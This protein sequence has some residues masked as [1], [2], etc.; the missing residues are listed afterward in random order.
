MAAGTG[1]GQQQP[2][3]LDSAAGDLS[4]ARGLLDHYARERRFY[5]L[6]AAVSAG[7]G[8]A[9]V[10]AQAVSA[11]LGVFADSS[12]LLFLC[13]YFLEPAPKL[14]QDLQTAANRHVL[15]WLPTYWFLGLFQPCAVYTGHRDS[16]SRSR[17][18]LCSSVFRTLLRS[19]QHRVVLAF[20][21]GL[22]FA[23]A[24]LLGRAP[25]GRELQALCCKTDILFLVAQKP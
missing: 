8:G 24:I 14:P 5:L 21:L 18:R 15:E 4:S 6:L 20:Y 2:A 23:I 12:I 7:R 9:V 22:G 10:A 11:S 13:G 25:V 1:S 16:A 17:Q 19:R 3:G